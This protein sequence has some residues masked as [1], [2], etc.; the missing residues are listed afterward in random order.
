M[1]EFNTKIRPNLVAK[2]TG[3][4]DTRPSC[5]RNQRR[6]KVRKSRPSRRMHPSCQPTI[7]SC[8]AHLR[9]SRQK[10]ESDLPV[11]HKSAVPER[12]QCSCHCHCYQPVQPS[13]QPATNFSS[14]F[15]FISKPF[16]FTKTTKTYH[17]ILRF[18][19][20]TLR[21]TC[22]L[23]LRPSKIFASFLAGYRNFTFRSSISPCN[24]LIPIRIDQTVAT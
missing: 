2:R 3:S 7:D 11:G 12:W 6:F 14:D 16:F 8:L 10:L 9:N 24:I 15:D 23:R 18:Q 20:Q 5:R 17:K 13:D 4:W 19:L 1:C 21:F 22:M